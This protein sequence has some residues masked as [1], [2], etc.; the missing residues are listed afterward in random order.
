MEEI[1][2][3]KAFNKDATNRYGQPFEEGKT[4]CVCGEIVFGNQGNGY[5]MCTNLC[6]VFRYVNACEDEV[7]VAEVTGCGKRQKMDDEYYG[8]Y[9]MYSF[10]KITVD[11]FMSREEI[12]NEMLSAPGYQVIKFLAT[13]RLTEEEK[14]LFYS[15]FRNEVD[16]IKNLLYYQ[17]GYKDVFENDKN[18][19]NYQMRLVIKDGQNNSKRCE[20]K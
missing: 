4:Y 20:R 15:K 11:R 2:G 6:D 5:H 14:I 9:D 19:D 10:E 12:I 18:K 13:F 16:V 1:K 7:L 3:Y 17:C 8:Y